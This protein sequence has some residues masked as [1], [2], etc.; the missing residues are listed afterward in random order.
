MAPTY[1]IDLA[2]QVFGDPSE[3]ADAIVNDV[4]TAMQKWEPSVTVQNVA[5]A[6]GIDST[7]GLVQIEVDYASPATGVNNPAA[8][9]TATVLVGGTVIEQVSP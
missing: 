7:T 3:V 1:G 9:S 5:I 4:T 2:G 8:V 6:P